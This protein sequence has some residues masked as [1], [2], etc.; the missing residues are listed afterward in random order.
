MS[1]NAHRGNDEL[2][3]AGRFDFDAVREIE[4]SRIQARREAVDRQAQESPDQAESSSVARAAGSSN[5]RNDLV[6]VSLSGGGIRSGAFSLGFLMGLSRS[7]I[8]KFVDYLSTVS[9]GGYAGAALSAEA[10]RLNEDRECKR[11]TDESLL[12]FDAPTAKVLRNPRTAENPARPYP[13]ALL[14]KVAEASRWLRDRSA[15]DFLNRFLIGGFT[16]LLTTFCLVAAIAAFTAWCIRWLWHPAVYDWL[17]AFGM[18]GDLM[19]ALTPSVVVFIAWLFCWAMSLADH[20]RQATGETARRVLKLWV[21][22]VLLGI[23]LVATSG[24]VDMGSWLTK[25]GISAE[26]GDALK[27]PIGWIIPA[28]SAAILTSLIPYLRPDK[29]LKSAR[30]EAGKE[31]YVF[32]AARWA[33]IWGVPLLMF[34]LFASED[35]SG[36]NMRRD[37]RFADSDLSTGPLIEQLSREF[38]ERREDGASSVSPSTDRRASSGRL[39]KYLLSGNSTTAESVETLPLI[40]LADLITEAGT[41]G[42]VATA[43][44]ASGERLT[45]LRAGNSFAD[46]REDLA[47]FQRPLH[48]VD[49]SRSSFA[50]ESGRNWQRE[51]LYVL[52]VRLTNPSLYKHVEED[53]RYYDELEKLAGVQSPRGPASTN[54]LSQERK[55]LIDARLEDARAA[56]RQVAKFNNLVD[57]QGRNGKI[58]TDEEELETSLAALAATLP[59]VGRWEVSTNYADR[60]D[61]KGFEQ[62]MTGLNK[63]GVAREVAIPHADSLVRE[64]LAHIHQTSAD[65]QNLGPLDDSVRDDLDAESARLLIQEQSARRAVLA[66]NRSLLEALYP[67]VIEPFGKT[68]YS[69]HVLMKDQEVRLTYAFWAGLVA[70]IGL[71]ISDLNTLSWHGYYAKRLARFWVQIGD[72]PD[73]TPTRIPMHLLNT[74]NAGRPYQLINASVLK[75]GRGATGVTDCAG[76]PVESFLLS[77]QF[78]GSSDDSELDVGAD[79]AELG[80]APTQ[81]RNFKQLMLADATALSGSAVSP[82]VIPN[83]LTRLLMFVLNMR[84][85]LWLPNPRRPEPRSTSGLKQ[86]V[87]TSQFFPPIHFLW[88]WLAHRDPYDWSY[89]SVTDGGFHENLGLE[90]LLTRRCSV[91]F[92]VDATQDENYRFDALASVVRRCRMFHG[93]EFREVSSGKPLPLP[94]DLAPSLDNKSRSRFAAIRIDYARM[95]A[96]RHESEA[97][98]TGLLILVKANLVEPLPLDLAHHANTNKQFPNDPTSDQFYSAEKFE[99]YRHLGDMAASGIAEKILNAQGKS[100]DLPVPNQMAF[101]AAVKKGFG[102]EDCSRRS[103]QSIADKQSPSRDI[104]ERYRR[105]FE[106][107]P[108]DK[109]LDGLKRDLKG[110]LPIEVLTAVGWELREAIAGAESPTQTESNYVVALMRLATEYLRHELR[111]AQSAETARD[112]LLAEPAIAEWPSLIDDWRRTFMTNE[113]TRRH[114]HVL[115]TAY[116]TLC[117]TS[118]DKEFLKKIMKVLSSA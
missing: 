63:Q 99:S 114:A 26:T 46:E 24:D 106:S 97:P 68:V 28:L 78:V 39:A 10:V 108:I 88:S 113:T 112:Q 82:W 98:K 17:Q 50:S 109:V 45:E 102:A 117:A 25:W 33:L 89:V 6:G 48:P 35:I 40:R 5:P 74:V 54:S 76:I 3:A 85:G 86:K 77:E 41:V 61:S 7:G 2:S 4:L 84:T 60:T 71:L 49:V 19:V 91:I 36:W 47:I 65:Q 79:S 81:S 101:I 93:I 104:L 1:G 67:G 105:A 27:R 9:G 87:T 111:D 20:K 94:L 21:V 37:H 30:E 115:M 62:W 75:F 90:S 69:R 14:R 11:K 43:G 22:V 100:G 31:R 51:L 16:T 72:E 110:H 44:A 80:F 13:K 70:I 55:K 23:V 116:Q 34:A 66:A 53:R 64:R 103:A 56:E 18:Q 12:L 59:Q 107:M 96:G 95:P 52:N 15:F 8:L 38:R 118:G 58:E 32:L 92:A 83:Q 42:R 29:L 57:S 73:E